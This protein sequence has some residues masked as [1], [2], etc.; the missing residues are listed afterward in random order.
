M[1]VE[2]GTEAAQFLEKEYKNRIF[3]AVY[4][5]LLTLIPGR[6]RRAE[7]GRWRASQGAEQPPA[8]QLPQ[9][10]GGVLLLPREVG[11]GRRQQE[12]VGEVGGG[13]VGGGGRAGWGGEVGGEVECNVSGVA[14]VAGVSG[15]AGL[16]GVSR[17]SGVTGVSGVTRVAGVA[18]VSGVSGTMDGVMFTMTGCL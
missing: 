12:R 3:L 11:V 9:Q 18:G 5:N 2:I 6:Q 13:G 17:V 1:N 16:T 4:V 10:K 7:E 14:G 15:V 8:L